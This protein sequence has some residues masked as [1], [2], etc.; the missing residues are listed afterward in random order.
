MPRPSPSV[1]IA[2]RRQEPDGTNEAL[3]SITL[4]SSQ[5]A[6]TTLALTAVPINRPK[7]RIRAGDALILTAVRDG[8]GSYGLG[9]DIPSLTVVFAVCSYEVE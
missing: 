8:T 1:T 4:S 2:V 6:G 9:V 3:A 7:A 5:A